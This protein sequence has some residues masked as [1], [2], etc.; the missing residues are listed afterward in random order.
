[1]DCLRQDAV[2]LIQHACRQGR[3]GVVCQYG[4]RG[5]DDDGPAIDVVSNKMYGTAMNF[6]AILKRACVS[7]EPPIRGQQ[8]GVNVD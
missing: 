7:V 3:G 8:G 6:Y 4:Y 5:L 1:M 2:L